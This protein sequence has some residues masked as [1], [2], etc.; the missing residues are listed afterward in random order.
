MQTQEH[1]ETHITIMLGRHHP[2]LTIL[3][4]F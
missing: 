3:S 1:K 2:R 4:F